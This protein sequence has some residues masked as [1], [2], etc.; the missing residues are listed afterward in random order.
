MDDPKSVQAIIAE[1]R[2]CI[3]DGVNPK[4]NKPYYNHVWEVIEKLQGIIMQLEKEI[5]GWEEYQKE[6]REEAQKALEGKDG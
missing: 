2:F 6:I 3:R 5:V 1:I 4:T